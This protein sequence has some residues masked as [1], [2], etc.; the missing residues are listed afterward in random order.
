MERVG[1][2]NVAIYFLVSLLVLAA[3]GCSSLDEK[4]N[5]DEKLKSEFKFE[6][7]LKAVEVDK[8]GDDKIVMGNPNDISIGREENIY[9]T[10]IQTGVVWKYQTERKS[11]KKVGGRGQGPGEFRSPSSVFIGPDDSLYVYDNRSVSVFSL[12]DGASFERRFYV[13]NPT[14]KIPAGVY[15]GKSG[16]MMIKLMLPDSPRTEE[17]GHW[18]YTMGKNGS[19]GKK[20]AY[21]SNNERIKEHENGYTTATYRPF[22]R[23]SNFSYDYQKSKICYGWNDSLHIECSNRKKS[24]VL[25]S[26]DYKKTEVDNKEKK[27]IR[28]SMGKEQLSLLNKKGFRDT[29]PAYEAFKIDKLGRIWISEFPK[30]HKD[31]IKWYIIDKKTDILKTIKMP[32]GKRI[33]AAGKE[34]IYTSSIMTPYVWI[35]KI[36]DN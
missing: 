5:M 15:I 25:I 33:L 31:K 20:L 16:K 13:E 21:L 30:H 10:D 27:E 18:I 17:S 34:K 36:K 14:G 7:K 24:E 11:L 2:A 22:G 1:R 28:N 8:I 26:L 4:K 23:K 6:G 9:I 19:V 32:M 29:H 3:V 12:S 35:Y